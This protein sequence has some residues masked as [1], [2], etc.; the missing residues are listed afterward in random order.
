M[1]PQKQ[2][3]EIPTF[4][5]FKETFQPEITIDKAYQQLYA[6]NGFEIT[7]DT[8]DLATLAYAIDPAGYTDRKGRPLEVNI[9]GEPK[10]TEVHGEYKKRTNRLRVYKLSRLTDKDR[11]NDIHKTAQLLGFYEDTRYIDDEVMLKGIEKFSTPIGA[12]AELKEMNSTFIHELQH[13][14]DNVSHYRTG[15]LSHVTKWAAAVTF[16]GAGVCYSLNTLLAAGYY[17]LPETISSNPANSTVAT[18]GILGTSVAIATG[19]QVKLATHHSVYYMNP[20]EI[21]A[22]RAEVLAPVL[23]KPIKILRTE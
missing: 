7:V 21:R 6:D 13:A 11:I 20:S 2:A 9:G 14:S 1:I 15:E 8:Q 22:R 3:G 12:Q 19:T 16:A 10:K 23:P 5:E 4:A 18:L 17:S